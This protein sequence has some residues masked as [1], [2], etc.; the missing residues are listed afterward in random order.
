MT[1]AT[2][3]LFERLALVFDFD[4]TLAEDSFDAL[5]KHCGF[6]PEA[7]SRKH[8]EPLVENGW[9]KVLARLYSLIEASKREEVTLDKSVLADVGRTVRL[10]DGV[11]EMFERVREAARAVV[12]EVK[13]EFYLL[14][15]GFAD[16]FRAAPI[17]D[18]FKTTWGCEI[19]FSEDGTPAFFKKIVTHAE[20]PR[21]LL[22]LSKGLHEVGGNPAEAYQEVHE[23]ELYI[24][25]SQ[26]IYVG[27]GSSDIPVFDLL[28]SRRGLALGIFKGESAAEWD[29]LEDMQHD[30][31]VQN[32]APP[33]Y[34][35]D[36]EL[37]RSLILATEMICKQIALRQ[38]S[39]GE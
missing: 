28:N 16:V 2:Q 11:T 35:E 10:F 4:G 9:E 32:L 3:P 36:S 6:D 19:H 8:V 12:P 7:F 17:V 5:L 21:Y 26:I 22:Q 20:K 1:R 30:R 27:D 23:S 38:L 15:S 13:V 39:V 29:G 37:M 34:S 25:L 18:E 33:G 24:P 14:S 31:R